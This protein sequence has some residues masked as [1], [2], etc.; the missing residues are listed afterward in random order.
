MPRRSAADLIPWDLYL[1]CPI[2]DFEL[3]SRT[4]QRGLSTLRPTEVRVTATE[5][6]F[7]LSVFASSHLH[8]LSPSFF[9]RLS[10]F[11]PLFLSL[12]HSFFPSPFYFHP[13][14]PPSFSSYLSLSLPSFFPPSFP[15]S[16]F[17]L[18]IYHTLLSVDGQFDLVVQSSGRKLAL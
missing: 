8:P 1:S 6:R 14:S 9:L 10:L 3:S 7:S 2:A 17:L 13:S 5:I 11:L 16:F 4:S 15:P 12:T 18:L